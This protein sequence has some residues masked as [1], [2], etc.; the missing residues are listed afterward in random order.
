VALPLY[1]AI[2]IGWLAIT[3]KA[4]EGRRDP[5]LSGPEAMVG[6]RA[7]VASVRDQRADARYKG[8]SWQAVS[9]LP[10]RAGEQVLIEAVEGLT[11]RVVPDDESA[12]T[13][14]GDENVDEEDL[15]GSE[16]LSP[17]S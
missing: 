1:V 8:E 4:L 5:P 13:A 6:D 15:T 2:T 16:R 12:R 11:L 7:V 14:G 10:L 3:R 17:S 9:S